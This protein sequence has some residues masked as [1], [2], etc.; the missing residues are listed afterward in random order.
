MPPRNINEAI[1]SFI[2]VFVVRY[3]DCRIRRNRHPRSRAEI[4]EFQ[5]INGT[6]RTEKKFTLMFTKTELTGELLTR[7]RG[8]TIIDVSGSSIFRRK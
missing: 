5:R 1:A 8:A 4:D 2:I 7:T 6:G 3:F